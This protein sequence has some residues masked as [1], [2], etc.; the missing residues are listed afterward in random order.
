MPILEKS[1]GLSV[2]R[3]F[4]V[5]YSP[6]RVNPGDKEHTIDKVVKIVSASDE[7]ALEIVC[8]IYG[9]ITTIHRARTIKI[10]EAAKVIENIQR[11]LNISLMNDEFPGTVGSVSPNAPFGQSSSISIG[12]IRT[13]ANSITTR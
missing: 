13:N 4:S 8:A 1:S 2:I 9:A 7:M 5:G 12:S 11:D 6:E 3:D 10:A